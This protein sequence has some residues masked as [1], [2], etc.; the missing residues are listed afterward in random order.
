[1]EGRVVTVSGVV[2]RLP[3]SGAASTSAEGIVELV[4]DPDNF[5]V[6]RTWRDKVDLVLGRYAG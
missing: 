5:D 1:M 2:T 3:C 4:E 6:R